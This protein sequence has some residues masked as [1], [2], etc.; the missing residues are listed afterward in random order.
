[1]ETLVVADQSMTD[2]YKYMDLEN[3]LLTIMNMVASL[4]RDSS[5]GSL[6]N[7][8]VVRIIILDNEKVNSFFLN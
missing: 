4:Y 6:I 8:V 5:L 7:I 1:M 2:R 3:Y